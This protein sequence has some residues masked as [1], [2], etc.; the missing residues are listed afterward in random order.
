VQGGIG[1]GGAKRM[2]QKLKPPRDL[3]K[4]CPNPKISREMVG[5]LIIKW[6]EDCEGEREGRVRKAQLRW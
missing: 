5:A 1:G 6:E 3:S 2:V 4:P